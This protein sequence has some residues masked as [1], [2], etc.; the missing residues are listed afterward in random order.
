MCREQEIARKWRRVWNAY[1][2]H[3]VT[4]FSSQVNH[5]LLHLNLAL[6]SRKIEKSH[7]MVGREGFDDIYD[8]KFFYIQR[9]F[10]SRRF[11]AA[12]ASL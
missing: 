11:M 3:N 4:W 6:K 1:R 2:L 7:I 12:V 5:V 9:R 10:Q 8:Y